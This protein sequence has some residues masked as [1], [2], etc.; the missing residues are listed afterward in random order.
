MARRIKYLIMVVGYFTKWKEAESVATISVERVREHP[1]TNGQAELANKVEVYE[2]AHIK[3][4]VTKARVA[5]RYIKKDEARINQIPSQ[6]HA[7]SLREAVKRPLRSILERGGQ[8]AF[9]GRIEVPE[10]GGQ[11]TP[12]DELKSLSEVVKRPLRT[13]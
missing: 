10:R 6:P 1:Q 9:L 3:E 2:V 4:Y 11:K 8:K 12:K 13:N 7:N 5:R